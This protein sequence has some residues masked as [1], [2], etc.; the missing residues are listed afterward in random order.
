MTQLVAPSVDKPYDLA[1]FALLLC[2]SFTLAGMIAYRLKYRTK[3]PM[4]AFSNFMNENSLGHI[5]LYII[6]FLLTLAPALLICIQP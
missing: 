1:A 4:V 6:L 2:A 5:V 3:F